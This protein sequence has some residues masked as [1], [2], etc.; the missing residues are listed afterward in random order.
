[1]VTSVND[2]FLNRLRAEPSRQFKA[3]LKQRL[4]RLA[5]ESGPVR[6]RRSY[7]VFAAALLIGGG[8]LAVAALTMRGVLRLP[9]SS[10]PWTTPRPLESPGEGSA[11]GSHDARGAPA[12][13]RRQLRRM[14]RLEGDAGGSTSSAPARDAP[15]AA[16]AAAPATSSRVS[17]SLVTHDAFA[18]PPIR[19]VV[20]SRLYPATRDFAEQFGRDGRYP[21]A[22][23]MSASS[24]SAI[25]QFCAPRDAP[26]IIVT[27]RRIR[28]AEAQECLRRGTLALSEY[29]V[30]SEVVLIARSATAGPVALTARDLYLALARDVPAPPPAQS[31]I[32]NPYRTWN[33]IDPALGAGDI[34]VFGSA[35][36][37]ALFDTLLARGC[38][39]FAW[40]AALEETDVA[41]FQGACG[42]LRADGVYHGEADPFTV[43]QA[44]LQDPTR[45]GVFDQ[46]F[47]AER[48][49]ELSASPIDGIEPSAEAVAALTYPGARGQYV[50]VDRGGGP[51]YLTD[52]VNAYLGALRRRATAYLQPVTT[53]G[54][55]LNLSKLSDLPP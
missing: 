33:Q 34:A 43:E 47:V 3:R 17:G 5:S 10:T 7:A 51:A 16:D 29:H 38:R 14:P 13:A 4:D 39:S 42:R 49:Q 2:D 6:P 46:R 41:G 52:F 9:G 45:L 31:L 24:S 21:T 36:D 54:Q 11:E 28:Q 35:D 40:I 19:I 50:Y 22:S 55:Y 25:A 18:S 23:V 53:R 8:A 44:I 12:P 48:P 1:M 26:Q 32:P 27:A 37:G 20:A 30:M 15:P